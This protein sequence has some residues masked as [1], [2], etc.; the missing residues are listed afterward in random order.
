LIERLDRGLDRK[1]ILV[2]APAGYGKTTLI[3]QWLARQSASVAWLSLDKYDNNLAGFVRYFCAALQTIFPGC[4][5]ET[6]GVLQTNPSI[7]DEDLAM[8]LASELAGLTEEFLL[9]LDDYHFITE[10]VVHQFMMT[11]LEYLP[12]VMSL[13]ITSRTDPPLGLARLRARQ[14]MLEIRPHQLRF[15]AAEIAAYLEQCLG[16]KPSSDMIAVLAERTEGWIAGLHLAV[17]ALQDQPDSISFVESLRG[18]YR[19]VM[20]YLLDEILSRQPPLVQA[21]LLQTSLLDRFCTPLAAALLSTPQPDFPPAEGVPLR[22]TSGQAPVASA[23]GRD[24]LKYLEQA[25]LFIVPLDNQGQWYRYHHLLQE[26][27]VHKLKAEK[28]GA[29]I[30]ALHLRAGRWLAEHG[31]DEEALPHLLAGG[32]MQGAAELVEKTRWLWGLAYNDWTTLDRQLNRLPPDLVQRRP[33]LLLA[34]TWVK[35]YQTNPGAIPS[36]LQAAESLLADPAL[37]PANAAYLRAEIDCLWGVIWYWQGQGERSFDHLQR[38]LPAASPKD[39]WFRAEVLLWFCVTAQMIGQPEL[40][41]QALAEAAQAEVVFSEISALRRLATH[42]FLLLLSGELSPALL[43]TE[44][45]IEIATQN[46]HLEGLGWSYYFRGLIHYARNELTEAILNLIEAGEYHYQILVGAT[47]DSLAGLALAYQGMRQ[48][49]EANETVT[50]LFEFT[51]QNQNPVFI[52]LAHS[53]Q[54]RLWLAQGDLESASRWLLRVEA[55]PFSTGHQFIW[56]EWVDCTICRVLLAQGT[57]ASLERA[58]ARLHDCVQVAEKT[59]NTRQLIE[60]LPLQAAVYQ[61]QGQTAAALTVLE[62]A[63]T[64]AQPGGFIRP[65]IE[66]GPAIAALLPTLAEQ[67]VAPAYIDQIMAA[68]GKDE[69]GRRKD[70]IKNLSSLQPSA[71]SPQPLLEPLTDR[72]LDVLALLAKHYSNDEIAEALHISI[73]TVKSHT[74][75]IYQKLAVKNRYQAVARAMTLQLLEDERS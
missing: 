62:R 42:I 52:A 6:R 17:L 57:S 64:L 34:Q 71:F 1:L 40:A 14:S 38:A 48:P 16:A 72:E 31:L 18:S 47:V 7:R 8:L 23:T 60:L 43:H 21:F 9:V 74:G 28:N 49:E 35:S 66:P 27:L 46:K 20:E 59:H 45:M 33:G 63:V 75:H 22:R 5:P 37:D 51:L 54:T 29:E 2:V 24:I 25:N 70:E 36:L 68:C 56:L 61:Q 58:S 44:E 13:V 65:F 39:I 30:T 53:T 10:L 11:L 67:G 12:P 41:Q 69:D 19:Y 3:N 32:D 55:N 4:C 26:L 73:P 15:S 50:R